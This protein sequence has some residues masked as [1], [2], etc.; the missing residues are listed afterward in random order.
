MRRRKH[1]QQLPPPVPGTRVEDAGLGDPLVRPGRR[2]RRARRARTSRTPRTTGRTRTP[3]VLLLVVGGTGL[4]VA[5]AARVSGTPALP[6]WSLLVVAGCAGVLV[7]AGV[8]ALRVPTEDAAPDVTAETAYVEPAVPEGTLEEEIGR[9]SAL[10]A[11]LHREHGVLY[12]SRT[13]VQDLLPALGVPTDHP[14]LVR[15]VVAVAALGAGGVRAEVGSLTRSYDDEQVRAVAIA[16]HRAL[17]AFADRLFAGDGLEGM[18][19]PENELWVH[20][21]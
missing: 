15:D 8:R 14:Q 1:H 11:L 2:S 5:A 7:L 13:W 3:G 18:P 12:G 17:D 16:L 4:G 21:A 6:E 9:V 10:L 19:R 20:A